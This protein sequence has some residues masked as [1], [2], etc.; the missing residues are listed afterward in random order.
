MT[1]HGTGC[2]YSAA[3]TA[4][5]GQGIELSKSV[6]LAKKYITSAIRHSFSLGQGN[7]PTN[8]WAPRKEELYERSDY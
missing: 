7:G 2:T 6:E 1:T 8:H 5:V 3:I 4:Y